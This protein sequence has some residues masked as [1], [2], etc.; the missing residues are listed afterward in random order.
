MASF[1]QGRSNQRMLGLRR[2]PGCHHATLPK[3]LY[4]HWFHLINQPLN[5]GKL[6]ESRLLERRYFGGYVEVRLEFTHEN[7]R[8]VARKEGDLAEPCPRW[9]L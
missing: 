7:K 1:G 5:T 4:P 8:I 6:K 2:R 3:L 9:T